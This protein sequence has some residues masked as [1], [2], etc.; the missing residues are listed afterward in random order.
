M[1]NNS[2]SNNRK[3]TNHRRS[4]LKALSVIMVL[5]MVVTA[6]TACTTYDNFKNSFL[7][8][9]PEVKAPTIK[10]GVYEPLSGAYKQ[11]GKD[12]AAGIE[13]A[14]SLYPTVL[15]KEVELI[16]ADNRSNMY[17][18]DTALQ[19]LMSQSPNFVLGSYGEVLS[20][21][22]ADYMVAYSTPAITITSTNPL[23][24]VNNDFYFTATFSTARQG[25]ALAEYAVNAL[26]KTSFAT[27]KA[28]RD[29]SA[30]AIIQR[31]N[32]RIKKL[33]GGDE[34]QKGNLVIDAEASDFSGCIEQLMNNQVETV[35]LAIP[36]AVAQT[37]MTQCAEK[38]YL[39]QFL[40][41]REWDSPDFEKY[42]QTSEYDL[43]VS[44]PS[45]QASD[46]T[47]TYQVFID[48]Y[49]KLN[50]KGSEPNGAVAAGFDSYRL[51]IKAIEDAYNNVKEADI[52]AMKAN[53]E[54]DAKSRAEIQ[55]YENTLETGIPSGTQI[56]DALKA[57]S[58][59]EGATG[60]LSYDGNAEVRKTV[61]ILHFFKGEK[62]APYSI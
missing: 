35:L 10:I 53:S 44:Y 6:M 30:T 58:G 39:P 33:T 49:E 29:D 59:F 62:L 45:V 7:G 46:N 16:Y 31:F 28:V 26:G 18:A 14:H 8:G 2:I 22:A 38:G 11:Y 54:L 41:T 51:A 1:L 15:G 43:S 56:R 20:L 34:S 48:A 36:P 4:F 55:D 52:E 37:F 47:D 5:V 24:T 25:A 17:D 23:I 61:T 9:N 13:L 3:V 40:G 57:V 27:V 19:E 60:V 12:E 42:L 50:G 32:N 21:V